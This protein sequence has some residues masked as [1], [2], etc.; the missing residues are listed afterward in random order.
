MRKFLTMMFWFS[1]VANALV[2]QHVWKVHNGSLP[3]ADFTDLP[4]A[5]AAASPGDVILVY[6]W[7]GVAQGLT[8]RHVRS[9]SR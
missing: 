8:T 9:T 5:V 3:G 7:L 4:Q 6:S 2:A 1:T